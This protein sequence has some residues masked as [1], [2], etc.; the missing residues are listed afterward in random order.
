MKH[1]RFDISRRLCLAIYGLAVVGVISC[2]QSGTAPG[3][4]GASPP[5][6]N[7]GGEPGCDFS[8]GSGS[9]SDPYQIGSVCE[10]RAFVG[11]NALWSSA[12]V[13]TSDI[14][15]AGES[16]VPM[17]DQFRGVLDG[18]GYALQNWISSTPLI[19]ISFGTIKNLSI[20]NTHIT[21]SATS[22]GSVLVGL[23]ENGALIDNCHVDGVL[24]SAMIQSKFV[25]PIAGINRGT[26]R[27]SSSDAQVSA[28]DSVGGLVGY[29]QGTITRSWSKGSVVATGSTLNLGAGGIAGTNLLTVSDSYSWSSVQGHA[30]A[31][32]LVGKN[33]KTIQTSYSI[34][35]VSGSGAYIGGMVGF[36]EVS[37]T[38]VIHSFWDTENSGL[39]T[40]AA[41]TGLNSTA[42]KTPSNFS[43]W[44]FVS[45]WSSSAGQY[46]WLQ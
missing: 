32:G 28:Q 41:G 5:L 40:S 27:D 13:L 26:V 19:Q 4:P 29:N 11:R 31:G 15:L 20:E 43:A 17:V 23:N 45:I 9:L 30:I 44:N 6:A 14:D 24:A 34:G 22:Q 46:P 36:N 25:G 42:M 16:F 21:L 10:L 39:S 37:G 3:D 33:L 2:A 8:G 7:Q 1:G 35:A 38:T 18:G 12:F